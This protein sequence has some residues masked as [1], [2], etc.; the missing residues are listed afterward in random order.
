MKLRQ[1]AAAILLAMACGCTTVPATQGTQE[2]GSDPLALMEAVADWQLAHKDDSAIYGSDRDSW[3]PRGWVQGAFFVGLTDLADRSRQPRFAKAVIDHGTAQEWRLGD[4][5]RHADDHVIGQ[6]Y[7]WSYHRL[8]KPEILAPMRASFDAILANPSTVSLDFEIEAPAGAEPPCQARWCWSDALF[9]SPPIWARL[10]AA[11]GDRRYLDYADAEFWAT[12]DYLYDKDEHLYYRDSRFHRRR[13]ANGGKIFWSRGNG[14]VF[15]GLARI[16]EVLPAEHPSRARYE[17]LLREMAAKLITLQGDAG[18]W[19]VSLL[20]GDRH[21]VPETSGT[22]FFVYGLAWGVN[23]GILDAATYQDSINRG[24][25]ALTRAVHA[26][27][28]LGWVQ[29]IGYAPDQ[30]AADDTQFYGVG[31]FLLAG[32]Q[33]H[34]MRARARK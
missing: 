29:R 2:S 34:D 25:A 4:R 10:S 13:D 30:V 8:G 5:L 15:A 9:M 7:L 11:V 17:T 20:S 18:Y 32:G 33:I 22:G 24:W 31:A 1:A 3:A 28:K 12:T 21:P 19:P 6:V 16:L 26:D 27:G 14:W 23:H